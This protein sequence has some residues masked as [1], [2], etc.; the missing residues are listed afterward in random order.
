M[1]ITSFNST[2]FGIAV[3]EYIET[4]L[5][6]SDILCV[7]EHFLLDAK[8]KKYSNTNK[9]RKRYNNCDMFIVPAHKDNNQVSKGRGKGG[10]A[11]IWSK[12]L[13][14]YVSKI[15][16]NNYRLQATKFNFPNGPILVINTY[17]PCDPRTLNFDDREL[18]TLLT[19]IQNI[20]Q[21]S[22]LTNVWLAGDLN[23][24]FLRNTTFTKLVKDYFLEIGLHLLWENRDQLDHL[25][26]V[27]YTFMSKANGTLSFST[28]DHFACTRRVF[29]SILEAGAIHSGENPSNHS[30]I[31]AKLLVGEVDLN[32][33]KIKAPKRV[34][35]TKATEDAKL[36][37]K[38]KLAEKLNCLTTP[39][40][41]LCTN[42]HCTEHVENLEDYTMDVLESIESIAKDT[43]PIRGGGGAGA[44]SRKTTPGWSEFVKPYLEESRFWHNLWVS[45]SKPAFGALCEA[46]KQSKQQYKYAV[47]RLKRANDSIQNDK[48]VSSIIHGG[49]NIFAEIKRFRG[50]GASCS[51]RIDDEVGSSNISNHFAE[52]YSDLYNKV[53][54]GPQFDQLCRQV[55]QDVGQHSLVQTDRI[56]EDLV[57]RA[58][59]LLKGNKGDALFEIQSDCL[60][61]GPPELVTHLT[62]ILKTFVIHGSIP[63]FILVCTLL[64][65]VKDNLGDI[66]SSDNYRAIASGSLLLKLL[67]LVILLLEG[68]KLECDPLQFG[69][70]ARSGT[71]MCTWTAS[72]VIDFFNKKGSVVYGCA[73]DLSKAFDMVDWKEL[74]VTLQQRDVDP[75]FLRILIFIYRN[76]QCDVRWNSS[77][78]HRFPVS[79]GVR[80]G[81]VSSPI[82]FSVYINDLICELR[83]AGLGC[84]IG[85]LFVGCLGY[86]DDLLLL[87]ASRCGLQSMVNTCEKFTGKKNLKFITNPD[88]SKSKTK[89]IIFS[90]KTKDLKNVAPVMLNGNPLPWVQ[91]VKHLGNVLQCDNSMKI[92]CTLKRGKF[93]GKVN[94]LLQ[95]FSYADPH[96]K[97]KIFSIFATSFYGSGLWDLYSN[98]VDSIFKSWNVT[99][100]IAYGVPP[101][102]HRYFI[103]PLAGSPPPKTMLSSRYI[104]FRD[105]LISSN[106]M[107]V[108]LLANLAVDDN[109][110]VMGRTLTRMKSELQCQDL[111][112]GKVKR[113]LKYFPTP[114]CDIW[115]FSFLEELLEV[116]SKKRTIENL[117]I[118]D[119]KSMIAALCT[120]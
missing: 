70:Q 87:S 30:A 80:Q 44:A 90:K 106:K 86:A 92:D 91:Q 113:E 64:P 66:T 110:T 115:R 84:H 6:F 29:P 52:I 117:S 4:L 79:N 2:G 24:H 15:Q 54:L 9:L 22:S 62:S 12:K 53:E 1:C 49:V 50:T 105:S 43:L 95:E 35:W 63:Y 60:I 88:P 77:Y 55:N 23:C 114:D 96:V 20:I 119:A 100:R 39:D 48:F 89:C 83:E 82:L 34:D 74:F 108:A 68:D 14:K 104:K 61:N 3:Q 103:E 13:T 47:R 101:T 25:S 32:M 107:E 7:Q 99:V 93:I 73:M 75:V 58:L 112:V 10:L 98:E 28:I 120:T 11:T 17:F 36:T 27:D 109:R 18:M 97:I 38:T 19:D 69:F 51:S 46:M 5:L 67:D 111:S 8:D 102:T 37:Y 56:N 57:K 81:A 40:C 45:A 33:E 72:A 41:V 59:K 116:E 76:Q 31:F 26:P 94:S 21:Q 16:S 78:S 71:V 42:V 65:L 85:G 118:T